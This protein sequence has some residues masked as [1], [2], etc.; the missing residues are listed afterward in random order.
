MNS[1]GSSVVD[2]LM[3]TAVVSAVVVPIILNKFG[4]PLMK[5]MTSERQKLVNFVGQ[6]PRGRKPPVPSTW[7]SQEKVAKPQGQ[8]LG[9]PGQLPPGAEL[10]GVGAVG[11]G[12]SVGS[13]DLAQVKDLKDP[14]QLQ[15]G[16]L[17]NTGNVGG[18]GAL[19][20][21]QSGPAGG[22]DFFSKPATPPGATLGGQE[23]KSATAAGSGSG[24]SGSEGRTSSRE[25]PGSESLMGESKKTDAQKEQADGGIDQKKRS[26]L[27]ENA[28]KEERSRSGSFDWWTLLKIL[29]VI[30][31]LALLFL[32]ALGNTR[33]GG[34]S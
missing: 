19:G 33:R 34:G 21:G 1:R 14:Q 23:E 11:G 25:Q 10:N 3:I 8:D 16:N 13:S 7:F 17:G 18:S 24:G 31:I 29:I 30:F 4:E 32:I 12:G 9:T 15:T 5:T 26:F 20:S 22:D 28:E 2:Y 27:A 6:T